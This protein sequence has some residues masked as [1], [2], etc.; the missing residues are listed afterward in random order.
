MS[1]PVCSFAFVH[2]WHR[3]LPEVPKF[4]HE[5]FD[6]KNYGMV[7]ALVDDDGPKIF[8]AGKLD[9]GTDR[10]VDADTVFD[11]CSITKTFTTLLLQD[12]VDS[13]QMQLDDPLAKYLPESVKLPVRDGQEITLRNLAAQDTGLPHDPDNV[14]PRSRSTVNPFESYT[15]EDA[16]TFLSHYTLPQRPGTDFV[17]SNL[18][19]A[20]LGH[21]MTRVAKADY[22]SLVVSRICNPLG[23]TSTR[24]TLTDD[25][26]SRRAIGH[27][28]SGKQAPNWEFKVYEGAGALRSTANDLLK[29][30]AANLGNGP[31]SISQLMKKNHAICHT[32]SS[33]FGDTAMPWYDR[34]QSA[35]TGTQLLG[36]AGGNGG[37][38]AFIGFN[39]Q[40]HRGVVVLSNQTGIVISEPVGWVV[41]ERITITPEL[42]NVLAHSNNKEL[43]GIGVALKFD[44]TTHTVRIDKVLPGSPASK[45]GLSAGLIVKTVGDVPIANKTLLQCQSMLRGTAGSKVRLELESPENS[46][47]KSVEIIRSP[48][49]T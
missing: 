20:L 40:Q 4:L 22:E 23:M 42:A 11:I 46:D 18:G 2:P 48:F 25:M 28:E 21:A 47:K 16:Y 5:T 37:Y 3:G 10:E 31:A 6:H 29:F 36:H 41:L 15:A 43:V 26:K 1:K 19:M 35:Q 24:I 34:D 39:K 7:I 9:N 33:T 13:G 49:K 32:G 38:N 17:Y 14:S 8:S 30:V 45:A 27:D 44:R 12:M